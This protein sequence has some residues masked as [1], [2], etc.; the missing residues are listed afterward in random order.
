MRGASVD[1]MTTPGAA[2]VRDLSRWEQGHA[3]TCRV[4]TDR[5]GLGIAVEG[6]VEPFTDRGVTHVVSV[7]SRG[8]LLGG[9]AAVALAAGSVAVR[10][11]GTGLLP[12]PEVRA[13]ARPDH[14]G[15]RHVLR[16]QSVLGPGHA[17][18]MVDDW[19]ERGSQAAAAREL[20]Q[21]CGAHWLGPSVIV[22]Q[23][24]Q[25]DRRALGDVTAL[26]SEP[27]WHMPGS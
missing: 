16:M 27:S 7:E 17:V 23:M 12:G 26:V 13:T 20:V 5:D 24:Q 25:S 14:Q 10:K 22:D 2:A 3:D 11:T 8:F 18:L 19:T 4:L 9:A 21:P 1:V 6:L 15:V